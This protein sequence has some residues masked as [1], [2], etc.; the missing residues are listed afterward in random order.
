MARNRGSLAVGAIGATLF[1]ASVGHHLREVSEVDGV[2]GPAVALALDGGLACALMY[3]GWWLERADLLE[4]LKRSVGRWTAA[5]GSPA[6]C[7]RC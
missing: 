7:W 6:A 1:V 3:A 5:G 4:E 2:V